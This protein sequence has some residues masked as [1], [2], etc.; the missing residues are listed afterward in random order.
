MEV[1]LPEIRNIGFRV[2]KTIVPKL[3][4]LYLWE[5]FKYLGGERLYQVPVTLGYFQSRL[6]EKDLNPTPHPFP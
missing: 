1:T 4:P 5:Q 6:P 2:V 3:Q